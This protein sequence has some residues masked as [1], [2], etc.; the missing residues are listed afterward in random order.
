MNHRVERIKKWTDS[1]NESTSV[2]TQ[3]QT[4]PFIIYL[5]AAVVVHERIEW[6]DDATLTVLFAA[7]K[8]HVR[9]KKHRSMASGLSLFYTATLFNDRI[10]FHDARSLV[11][12]Q[13]GGRHGDESLRS[14]DFSRG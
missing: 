5:L 6:I 14:I 8:A 10:C 1:E 3:H 11:Q 2:V 7:A 9:N 4:M 12:Q 13:P